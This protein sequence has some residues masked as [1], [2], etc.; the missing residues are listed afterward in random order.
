M[1]VRITGTPELKRRLAAIEQTFK[2][3]G[4]T[5]ADTTAQEMRTAVPVRTGKLRASFRRRNATAKKATVV[6]NF[7]A[8]FVDA[9]TKAHVE[10]PKNKPSMVF[11]VQGRTVFSKKVM[12]PRTRPQPFRQ[13]SA[14]EG[15]RKTDMP[16]QLIDLWNHGA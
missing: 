7:T 8:Y 9:G 1:P 4:R 6:G 12:H 2:P 14:D 11:K 16:K 5:W 10:V 13:R 15:L 3:I